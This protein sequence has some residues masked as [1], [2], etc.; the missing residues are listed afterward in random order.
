MGEESG[1]TTKEEVTGAGKCDPEL[2]KLA[3]DCEMSFQRQGEGYGGYRRKRSVF[4]T[5]WTSKSDQR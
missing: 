2:E 5:R 4:V 1:E 3:L